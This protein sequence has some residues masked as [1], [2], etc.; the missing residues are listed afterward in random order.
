MLR[1]LIPAILTLGFVLLAG[2]HTYIENDMTKTAWAV[3]FANGTM[4]VDNLFRRI[5]EHLRQ[6]EAEESE[7]EANS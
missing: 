4:L 2:Y 6:K 5:W 3:I 1:S 7:E